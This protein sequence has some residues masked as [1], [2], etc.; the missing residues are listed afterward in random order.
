V[1]ILNHLQGDRADKILLKMCDHS[2]DVVR[3]KAIKELVG[4]DPKY[5]KKLFSLIDDPIREI[6]TCFLEAFA[7]YR[8]S[9]LENM[10]LKYLIENSAKKDPAHIFACY[11]ALGHCGSNI[12]VPFLHRILLN[13]G[14]NSFMG[15]GKL[16][17]RESAAIAIALIDT[18]EAKDVLEEA[19]KSRFKVIRKA[20]DKTQTISDVSGENTN[21]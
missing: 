19:S 5:A 7:K 12:A 18:P 20:F 15:S 8:S 3:R 4:R 17:F 1:L 11:E 6:R 9:E 13:Q 10:L 16:I 21:D 14:W 2:S